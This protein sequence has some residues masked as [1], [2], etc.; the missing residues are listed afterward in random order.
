MV[1]LDLFN[2]TVALHQILAPWHP[3]TQIHLLHQVLVVFSPLWCQMFQSGATNSFL[4]ILV[5]IY[6][7]EDSASK[8]QWKSNN[9]QNALL[10]PLLLILVHVP[11][12]N[13]QLPPIP[14]HQNFQADHAPSHHAFF[15]TSQQHFSD[16]SCSWNNWD[17]ETRRRKEKA[18][19]TRYTQRWKIFCVTENS[20]PPPSYILYS[21][22]PLP[23]AP[24]ILP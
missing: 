14:V 19:T 15:P 9:H 16:L 22:P 2:F 1:R 10:S 5:T 11:L 18:N 21:K 12:P 4:C 23:H 8:S 24:M 7:P 20:D 6:Q 3:I 17:L 13:L